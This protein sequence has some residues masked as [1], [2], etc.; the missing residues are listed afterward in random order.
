MRLHGNAVLR[1]GISVVVVVIQHPEAGK[2]T[3]KQF[4]GILGFSLRHILGRNALPVLSEE[5]ILCE[6]QNSESHLFLLQTPSSCKDC[7]SWDSLEPWP[8][9]GIDCDFSFLMI[10]KEATKGYIHDGLSL[11]GDVFVLGREFA[12]LH[13]IHIA[14]YEAASVA[15]WRI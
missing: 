13:S 5:T 1:V 2:M 12:R 7:S 14:G 4:V 3:S 15:I 8:E 11:I 10:V 6:V 9:V